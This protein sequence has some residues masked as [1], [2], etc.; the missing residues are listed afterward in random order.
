MVPEGE[1]ISYGK[2]FI[3]NRP[4]KIATVPVGYANGYSR[5]LSNNGHVLVNGKRAMVVG[6]VN[7]NMMIIDVT[8][9]KDIK[10]GD[11]VVLIG[12]QGEKTITV[13]SFSDMNNS[14]NYE[15]L[16]RLPADI[17]RKVVG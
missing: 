14:M 13:S 5:T 11:E 9:D 16:T 6:I 2:T 8:E 4:T 12:T 10:I 3:T 15:L 17:P 7:M 1:F